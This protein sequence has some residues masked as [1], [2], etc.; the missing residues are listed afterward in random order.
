VAWDASRPVPYKRL[1]K[2]WVIYAAIMGVIFS[3]FLRDSTSP[4]GLFIG[5]A[6]SLPLYMGLSYVM[7]KFGYQRKSLGELR[8]PRAAPETG[9]PAGSP[10]AT[11][12]ARPA[13]TR[14]TSGGT[15]PP[16]KRRR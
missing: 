16:A 5:L 6:A 13:P 8:T 1:A 10:P 3:V 14:R 7:A 2:E 15:K 12:R 9:S 11:A 4:G